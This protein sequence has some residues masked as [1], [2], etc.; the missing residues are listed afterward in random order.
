MRDTLPLGEWCRRLDEAIVDGR[1]GE[2]PRL[3]GEHLAACPRCRA[4]AEGYRLLRGLIDRSQPQGPDGTP[5]PA[6]AEPPQAVVAAFA[7][8]R[9]H[10]RRRLVGACAAGA[11]GIAVAGWLLLRPPSAGEPTPGAPYPASL[12]SS[13]DPAD[14]LRYAASLHRR[15]MPDPVTHRIECFKKDPA[16]EREFLEALRHPSAVVRRIAYAHLAGAGRPVPVEETVRLLREARPGLEKPLELAAAGDAGRHLAEA[17]EQGRANL[18]TSVLDGLAGTTAAVE[19]KVPADVLLPYVD[20]ASARVRAAALYALAQD[21]AYVP[22]REIETRVASDPDLEVRRAAAALIVDRGGVAGREWLVGS[23]TRR[24]DPEVEVTVVPS[25][26]T[27]E[28]ALAFSQAR[29]EDPATPAVLALHHARRLQK[30]GHPLDAE[31]LVA[32]GLQGDDHAASLAALLASAGGWTQHRAALMERWRRSSGVHQ[33]NFGNLLAKWYL[34][35]DEPQ[36]FERCF[37]ILEAGFSLGGRDVLKALRQQS[38]PEV[39]RRAEQIAE[40]WEAVR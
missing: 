6:G 1:F 37:E 29:M 12:A 38:D 23:F 20:D 9:R 10:R 32:L 36:R 22:G 16:L 5:P 21:L 15:A 2:D 7:T 30:V 8:W 4:T 18:L 35:S 3:W 33:S 39:R 27:S 40:R 31:R 11:A 28:V 17:L 14:A 34:A 24:P 25:L 26:G 13:T 19:R